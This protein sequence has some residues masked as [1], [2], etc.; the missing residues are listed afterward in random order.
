MTVEKPGHGDH[1]LAA[2]EPGDERMLDALA[3][4][5]DAPAEPKAHRRALTSALDL[6]QI[7]AK[8]RL[9]TAYPE[10][11]ATALVDL[12]PRELLLWETGVE[13]WLVAEHE[14]AGVLAF[15]LTDLLEQADRYQAVK[16]PV[17]L[18]LG[19]LAYTLARAPA[20]AGPSRLRPAR[21]KDERFLPDDYWFEADVL[22]ATADG[23]GASVLDL[24]LHGGLTLPVVAR[25][26]PRLAAGER[27][28]GFLW[29]TGRWPEGT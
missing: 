28:Q 11:R 25:E 2:L 20:Q 7:T 9:L 15:F 23:E 5:V 26:A 12:K 1:W 3:A 27:A 16:G 10:P 18:E 24:A 4:P 8:R 19:A 21:Q 22:G 29:L 6:V 14:G 13:G 17:A